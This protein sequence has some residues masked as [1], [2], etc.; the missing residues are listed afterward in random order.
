MELGLADGRFQHRRF[1]CQRV[2]VPK[3]PVSEVE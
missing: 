2:Y 3:A 1:L